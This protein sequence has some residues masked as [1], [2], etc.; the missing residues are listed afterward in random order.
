MPDMDLNTFFVNTMALMS[1]L[2]L[3]VQIVGCFIIVLSLSFLWKY[4]IKGLYLSFKLRNLLKDLRNFKKTKGIDPSDLFSAKRGREMFHLWTEYKDTLHPQK[5]INPETGEDEIHALRATVPAETFFS[6]QALV[7]SRLSA[8]FFRHLPGIFTGLGI[9]GT[10]SGLIKGLKAFNVSENTEVVRKSLES[11][12]A[13][14]SEAFVVSA[15]AIG[16]AMLVTLIEKSLLSSLHRKIEQLCYII[17]SFFETGAG[18][19]YLERLVKASEDSTVQ[20]KNLKDSFIMELKQTMFEL[21]QK[22]ISAFNEQMSVFAHATLTSQKDLSDQIVKSIE[23]GISKPLE[24]IAEVFKGQRER[25]GDEISSALGDVLSSFS[26]DQNELLGGQITGMNDLQQKTLMALESAVNQLN[27]MMSDLND[28]GRGATDAMAEKMTDAVSSMEARQRMMNATMSEFVEQIRNLVS[29]SQSETS[30]K[31]QEIISELGSQVSLM[32]SELRSQANDMTVMNKT[33]HSDLSL[34][35]V[36]AI[37]SVSTE[38]KNSMQT[39]QSQ[40][41]QLLNV[42]EKQQERFV[43]RTEKAVTDFSQNVENTVSLSTDKTTEMIGKLSRMVE[44][45]NENTTTAVRSIHLAVTDLTEITGTSARDMNEGSKNLLMSSEEFGK[46]SRGLT[47]ILD[48]LSLIG[49]DMS[50]S[51]SAVAGAARMLEGISSDFR[52]SKQSL[53]SMLENVRAIVETARREASLTEDVLSRIE[54]SAQKLFAAQQQ[55]DGYLSSVSEVL[56]AT[57][58]E[59]SSNMRST[60]KDVNTQFFDHLTT[61][62]SKLREGI[63]ELEATIGRIGGSVSREV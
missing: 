14:V 38:L 60:L 53:S 40:I 55:A 16:L 10:F 61:A 20:S 39:M 24:S 52:D 43:D 42:I 15:I 33:T 8:D 11:L 18:E 1:A 36:N 32:V 2:P 37:S 25:A 51:S 19:E 5:R 62:V 48:K 7:D 57:H 49:K 54:G 29:Q 23:A 3:Q 41:L 21:N 28:A 30:R 34:A 46:A 59:F 4:L 63:E 9:I 58:K 50:S 27:K 17:D 6:T 26:K 44:T 56:T 35:T 45:S 22:Q 47:G 31:L 12:L 13:G